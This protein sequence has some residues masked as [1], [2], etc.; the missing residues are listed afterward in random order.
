[1][2][3]DFYV[4]FGQK[5]DNSAVVDT[6]NNTFCPIRS[7][8][9]NFYTLLPKLYLDKH[10]PAEHNVI[11]KK[12]GKIKAAVGLYYNSLYLCGETLKT[13]GIGNVAVLP[14]ERGNG[15]MKDCMNFAV[16][17]IKKSGADFAFLDGQRQRYGY[18]GFDRGGIAVTLTVTKANI[19]HTFGENAE[20][21]LTVKP[22][23]P[24]NT[25]YLSQILKL[26]ESNRMHFSRDA[27]S[28]YEILTSWCSLPFVLLDNG[29]FIGYL[30]LNDSKTCVPEINVISPDYF[31]DSV[32]LAL[33]L[34]S[35]DRLSFRLPECFSE[36]SDFLSGFADTMTKTYAEMISVFNY[37]KT[38]TAFLK[39]CAS[40]KKLC[41]CDVKLLIHG[42]AGDERLHIRIKSNE[43]YVN[44]FGG[45]P[46]T[47][48]THNE[49]LRLLLSDFSPAHINVPVEF[50]ANLPLPIFIYSADNV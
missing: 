28:M 20:S 19:R 46:D 34:A 8:D 43:V 1:M 9:F 14:T 2:I 22:L 16:D 45:E 4:G 31:K 10:N 35:G 13:A 48:L 42:V 25:E 12:D 6:I 3:N 39:L 40:Y 7:Q 24:S 44:K 49:A 26:Y 30:I 47:E 23:L 21:T 33:T 29:R 37:T 50:S 41:D 11:V 5:E 18:F 27:D 17:D 32:I 15:Y 38:V 36:F